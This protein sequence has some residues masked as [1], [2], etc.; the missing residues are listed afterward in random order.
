M[1]EID[2]KERRKLFYSYRDLLLSGPVIITSVLKKEGKRPK[3]VTYFI[4]SIDSVLAL[5][6]KFI[7]TQCIVLRVSGPVYISREWLDTTPSVRIIKYRKEKIKM[8]LDGMEIELPD[9][10]IEGEVR[11]FVMSRTEEMINSTFSGP[12]PEEEEDEMF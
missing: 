5:D 9:L 7:R 12:T 1:S 11:K 3:K 8:S 4:S 10:D 2:I 6:I